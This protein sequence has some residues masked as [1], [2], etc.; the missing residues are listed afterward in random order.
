MSEQSRMRIIGR[1]FNKPGLFTS[2]N[3]KIKENRVILVLY[4]INTV[5]FFMNTQVNCS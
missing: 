4:L 2:I 1:M 3:K 5:T